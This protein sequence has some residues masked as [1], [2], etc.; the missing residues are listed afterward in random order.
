LFLPQFRLL[1]CA[2]LLF[3][4]PSQ[5]LD[6]LGGL[7]HVDVLLAHLMVR[8][9]LVVLSVRGTVHLVHL[10]LAAL[11]IQHILVGIVAIVGRILFRAAL[12]RP[13]IVL[14]VI[15]GGLRLVV[16]AL[17]SRLCSTSAGLVGGRGVGGVL[18]LFAVAVIVLVIGLNQFAWSIAMLAAVAGGCR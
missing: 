4:R 10:R 15:P 6:P 11:E 17:P 3:A 9:A 18:L 2:Y 16:M 12:L 14:L 1:P 8:M 13:G 7:L 5:H